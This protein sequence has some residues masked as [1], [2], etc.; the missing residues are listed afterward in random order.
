MKKLVVGIVAVAVIA[1]LMF[2]ESCSKFEEG[3]AISFSTET[4]RLVGD[5]KLVK[6]ERVVTVNGDTAAV[7][8]FDGEY[9]YSGIN[10]IEYSQKLSI[11]NYGLVNVTYVQSGSDSYECVGW[12]F[13][14]LE[15]FRDGIQLGAKVF[16]IMR[17]TKNEMFLEYYNYP[18]I[19]NDPENPVYS[20]EYERYEYEKIN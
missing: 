7:Y 18:N 16:N 11:E 15:H 3:P 12:A 13:R 20:N 6:W 17:L 2:L 19:S 4:A 8:S 1:G 5:W 10:K 14:D 9:I